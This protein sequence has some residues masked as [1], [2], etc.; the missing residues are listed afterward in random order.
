MKRLKFI[1]ILRTNTKQFWCLFLPK[2]R[3]CSIIDPLAWSTYASSLYNILNQP[4]I[5]HNPQYHPC[6]F[7]IDKMVL[8]VICKLQTNKTTD[9]KNL[10]LKFF[11]HN[12]IVLVIHI[13]EMF[14]YISSQG[15]PLL[16]LQ[17]H[18]SHLQN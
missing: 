11:K 16:D 3:L 13:V 15:S 12:P 14:N 18:P 10:S 17:H 5:I 2:C 8:R 4:Y 1:K 9:S 7:F 6:R